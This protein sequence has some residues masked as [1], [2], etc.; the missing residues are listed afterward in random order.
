M[1]IDRVGFEPLPCH[2]HWAFQIIFKSRKIGRYKH[3]SFQFLT[4]VF[5]IFYEL[6]I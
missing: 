4:K 1:G 3:F 6:L 2:D 5:N